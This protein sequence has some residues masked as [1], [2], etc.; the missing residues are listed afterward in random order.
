MQRQKTGGERRM[1]APEWYW[2]RPMCWETV[3]GCKEWRNEV[4]AET[5]RRFAQH[6]EDDAQ[7]DGDAD[8]EAPFS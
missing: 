7:S 6:S 8:A 3:T 2:V 4:T 5:V 1:Y